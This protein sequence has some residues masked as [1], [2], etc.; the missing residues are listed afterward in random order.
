[1]CRSG[2]RTPDRRPGRFDARN[3]LAAEGQLQS[4]DEIGYLK[5]QGGYGAVV[6]ACFGERLAQFR[7]R[8][9][10][11]AAARDPP[12]CRARSS[13][14]FPARRSSSILLVE[15][16]GGRDI[17]QLLAAKMGVAVC[18][19]TTLSQAPLGQV[20]RGGLPMSPTGGRLPVFVA[21][22][23]ISASSSRRRSVQDPVR[24]RVTATTR[25]VASS[26]AITS[27]ASRTWPRQ[28]HHS[29]RRFGGKRDADAEHD[30]ADFGEKLARQLRMG[31][32][33]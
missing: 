8:T 31:L 12:W 24:R 3:I 4:L 27:R 18:E 10:D 2:R 17:R 29:D 22:S 7:F 23:R 21:V 6:G 5:A 15:L 33:L 14:R 20:P 13:P 30:D 26:V 9:P 16:V 25:L 32:G 11:R 19:A 1:M 28:C